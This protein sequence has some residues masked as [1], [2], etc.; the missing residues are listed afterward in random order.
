V[1]RSSCWWRKAWRCSTWWSRGGPSLCSWGGSWSASSPAAPATC[2]PATATAPATSSGGRHGTQQETLQYMNSFYGV[3]TPLPGWMSSVVEPITYFLQRVK[4]HNHHMSGCFDTVCPVPSPSY[5]AH[6][7]MHNSW[8]LRLFGPMARRIGLVNCEP[9][10]PYGDIMVGMRTT[11]YGNPQIGWNQALSDSR[12]LQY[13]SLD[14]CRVPFEEAGL[15][16]GFC[17]G[18]LNLIWTM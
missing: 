13:R 16:S 12:K 2:W 15:S 10:V 17:W 1:R 11:A 8:T 5:S 18:A 6:F 3:L 14:G 4:G 9:Q 7:D